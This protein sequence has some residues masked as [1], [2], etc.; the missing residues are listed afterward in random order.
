MKNT[1]L[2]SYLLSKYYAINIIHYLQKDRIS[3]Y[4][5]NAPSQIQKAKWFPT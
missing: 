2:Y 3:P 4:V 1:A 5:N